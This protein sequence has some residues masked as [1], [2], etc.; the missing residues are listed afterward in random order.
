MIEIKKIKTDGE[1]WRIEYSQTSRTKDAPPDMLSL[2]SFEAAL[3]SFS[4]ALRGLRGVVEKICSLPEGYCEAM[5]IRGV[6]LSYNESMGVTISGLRPLQA[7]PAPLVLNTPHV[8]EEMLTHDELGAVLTVLREAEKY[9]RGERL[10][11]SLFEVEFESA[12]IQE[13]ESVTLR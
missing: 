1:K 7:C 11:A 3:S 5:D 10:Q 4:Q 9:V 12:S 13:V 6:S 8:L 2:E